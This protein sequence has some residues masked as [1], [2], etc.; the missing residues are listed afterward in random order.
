MR[1]EPLLFGLPL[2]L[3]DVCLQC[4]EL[5]RKVRL[6]LLDAGLHLLA[7]TGQIAF[8][9]SLRASEQEIANLIDRG[10]GMDRGFRP[11]G[12]GSS[13]RGFCGL[14]GGFHFLSS[15]LTLTDTVT[16][17]ISNPNSCDRQPTYCRRR[18]SGVAF[19]E[20][21]PSSPTAMTR[22]TPVVLRIGS[23]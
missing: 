17:V 23:D 14:L 2:E 1:G 22:L 8:E 7:Q 6:E 21:C 19:T 10:L 11:I 9:R 18:L 15:A 12:G 3:Q 13:I 16:T 4:R 20:P 5:L